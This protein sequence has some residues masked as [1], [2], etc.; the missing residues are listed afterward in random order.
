M[1]SLEIIVVVFIRMNRVD[2][3]KI[4]TLKEYLQQNTK[5]ALCNDKGV[6]LRGYS[7]HKNIFL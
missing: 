1:V 6:N 7:F 5:G 4:K 2:S 3:K